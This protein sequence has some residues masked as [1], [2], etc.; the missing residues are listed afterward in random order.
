[1]SPATPLWYMFLCCVSNRT[2]CSIKDNSFQSTIPHE[3]SLS[4]SSSASS[5]EPVTDFPATFWKSTYWMKMRR[6]KPAATSQV[7][8]IH[9][10]FSVLRQESVSHVLGVLVWCG[11]L[12][13]VIRWDFV[14][15]RAFTMWLWLASHSVSGSHKHWMYYELLHGPPGF[16]SYTT[17]NL[18]KQMWRSQAITH[19]CLHDSPFVS[20]TNPTQW[21]PSSPWHLTFFFLLLCFPLILRMWG[22]GIGLSWQC[23]PEGHSQWLI[24]RCL[25][26]VLVL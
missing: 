7:E 9:F 19:C 22:L 12:S 25:C 18:N 14:W 2:Q 11:S 13:V 20:S 23:M 17:T 21:Q 3:D 4:G 1:M 26:W 5:Y 8:G 16:G 15:H 6:I 10:I 24:H